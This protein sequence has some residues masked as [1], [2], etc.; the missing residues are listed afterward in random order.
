[1][2]SKLLFFG[3]C[4]VSRLRRER[5]RRSSRRR[6]YGDPAFRVTDQGGR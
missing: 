2:R 3:G 1:M 4:D 6:G 5:R